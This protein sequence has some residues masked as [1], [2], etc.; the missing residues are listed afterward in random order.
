MNRDHMEVSAAFSLE[1]PPVAV[2]WGISESELETLLGQRLRY[3]TKGYY[4]A[5]CTSFP[6]LTHELGFHFEPRVGGRLVELEFFRH[7]YQNLAASYQ[8]FQR[9]FESKFGSPSR[10]VPGECGFPSHEWVLGPIIVKH[11]VR[12]R[13]GPEEH[14]R[15]R[16]TAI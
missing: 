4:T 10:S 1:D 15:V 7:S 13:F 6:Q 14:M 12:E 11:F 9:A 8:E 5:T 3:I 2:P 16:S